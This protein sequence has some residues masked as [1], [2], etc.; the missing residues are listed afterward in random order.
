[1]E[2]RDRSAAEVHDLNPYFGKQAIVDQSYVLTKPIDEEKPRVK[3]VPDIVPVGQP[4]ADTAGTM[5]GLVDPLS[6]D[7]R[8]QRVGDIYD[9]MKDD[10]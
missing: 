1:M 10:D 6:A 2:D 7:E 5:K 9:L 8:I 3:D 4:K